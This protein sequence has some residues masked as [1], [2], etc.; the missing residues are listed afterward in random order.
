MLIYINANLS[1]EITALIDDLQAKDDYT[2]HIYVNE[3][4]GDMADYVVLAHILKEQSLT[5]N[6]NLYIVG[7]I[8]KC[9]VSLIAELFHYVSIEILPSAVIKCPSL[10]EQLLSVEQLDLESLRFKPLNDNIEQ[11]ANKLWLR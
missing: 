6:I 8:T 3:T 10:L 1:L 4:K 7:E 11:I 2:V 5:R 9:I